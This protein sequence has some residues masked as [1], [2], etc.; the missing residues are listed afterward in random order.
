MKNDTRDEVTYLLLFFVFSACWKN[1]G[2][3]KGV[4]LCTCCHLNSVDIGVCCVPFL[5]LFVCF[6]VVWCFCVCVRCFSRPA[7]QAK[8]KSIVNTG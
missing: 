1:V 3:T 2:K 7:T 4:G 5:S 6:V 8:G